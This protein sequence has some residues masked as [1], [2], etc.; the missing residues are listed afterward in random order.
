MGY[1]KV[2]SSEIY[3]FQSIL[4]YLCFEPFFFNMELQ[5]NDSFKYHR[6]KVLARPIGAELSIRTTLKSWQQS[7]GLQRQLQHNTALY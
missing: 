1:K 7:H 4:F 5:I 3:K 6:L 2:F